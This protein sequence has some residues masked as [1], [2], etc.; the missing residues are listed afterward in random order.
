[1]KNSYKKELFDS[2]VE[3]VEND[4]MIEVDTRTLRMI[5]T[6]MSEIAIEM[7][8]KNNQNLTELYKNVVNDLELSRFKTLEMIKYMESATNRL[9]AAFEKDAMIKMEFDSLKKRNVIVAR[10]SVLKETIVFLN[11]LNEL[12]ANFY[13]QVY[14]IDLEINK[15]KIQGTLF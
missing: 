5:A 2:L 6:A 7:G 12:V 10:T 14:K 8:I 13:E 15:E 1:M 11:K 4:E 3:V 9:I